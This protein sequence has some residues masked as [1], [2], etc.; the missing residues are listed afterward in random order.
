MA[1]PKT[2]EDLLAEKN[3]PASFE[4]LLAGK[5]VS[6]ASYP[7]PQPEPGPR[8]TGFTTVAPGKIVYGEPAKPPLSAG[9]FYGRY[10]KSVA[11]FILPVAGMEAGAAL[12]PSRLAEEAP[13]LT[14]AGKTAL[15]ALGAGAGGEAAKVVRGETPSLAGGLHTARNVALTEGLI[16]G[17]GYTTARAGS[18]EPAAASMAQDRPDLLRKAPAEE[19]AGAAKG[20]ARTVQKFPETAE[21]VEYRGLVGAKGKIDG[22]P[23]V[24]RMLNQVRPNVDE[25]V[26]RLIESKTENLANKLFNRLGPN[27]EIDAADL[28]DWIAKNLREPASRTYEKGA[29]TVW[30]ERLA[31]MNDELS[32]KLYQDIGG[33]AP[34]LQAA[35]HKTLSKVEG[36][37]KMFPEQTPQKPN[38]QSP[39]M[40]R[41]VLNDTDIGHQVR[42][43]LAGLDEV[44]GT[45]HLQRVKDLAMRSSW[46]AQE[47]AEVSD[48]LAN[49]PSVRYERVGMV[50]AGARQIG[51][52]LTRLARPAGRTAA[53]VSTMPSPEESP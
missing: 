32:P 14:M 46:T 51:R 12:L 45:K 36:A 30:Q 1:E 24:E 37:G 26:A 20:I 33:K 52:G 50:R 15:R 47:K 44:A 43:R 53:V 40:L 3:A 10:I 41:Q 28:D 6:K 27:G 23:Y 2:F 29:G 38:I 13:I 22:M 42:T 17:L 19:Y 8:P 7:F 5:E 48:I 9:Q 35:T 11:P 4:D 39:G 18:V 49:L 34:E 31:S 16:R 21:H 25:N